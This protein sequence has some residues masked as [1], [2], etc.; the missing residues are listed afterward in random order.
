MQ[1]KYNKY[2]NHV[3]ASDLRRLVNPMA[4]Q[5]NKRTR[6]HTDSPNKETCVLC[7]QK[8]TK[9]AVQCDRCSKWEH[10]ACAT[11]ANVSDN[12]YSEINHRFLTIHMYG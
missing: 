12:I 3:R 6:R 9:N 4:S 1:R 11:C 8:A 7:N 5:T 10:K 2:K